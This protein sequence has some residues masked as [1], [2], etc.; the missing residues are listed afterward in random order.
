VRLRVLPAKVRE[1]HAHVEKFERH[2]KKS[3][4]QPSGEFDPWR[5]VEEYDQ[6]LHFQQEKN[7]KCFMIVKNFM[8]IRNYDHTLL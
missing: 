6:F 5:L 7:C 3:S 2:L 1:I 8:Q 4:H